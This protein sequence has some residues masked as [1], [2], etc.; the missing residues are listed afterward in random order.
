[1]KQNLR[2]FTGAGPSLPMVAAEGTRAQTPGSFLRFSAFGQFVDPPPAEARKHRYR[3]W[4]R[5]ATAAVAMPAG[6]LPGA[7]PRRGAGSR[8]GR[9]TGSGAR[10]AA[11]C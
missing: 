11:L 2:G 9:S 4:R 1:M 7:R 8:R 5:V 3:G 6:G 10:L